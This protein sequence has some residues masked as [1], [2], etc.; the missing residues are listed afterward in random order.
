M[1]AVERLIRYCRIDTQ[2]DP[3]SNT[4]PSTAKQFDLAKILVRELKEV[5]AEDA[6]LDEY[7][8]VY[9]HI[10][11]NTERKVPTVGFIAH[12]DTA[13]DFTGAGVSPRIIENY[14]GRDIQ[15]N[16]TVVTRVSQFPQM[17]ELKGKTLLVTDGN[18]LLGADDKAGITA[19][20]EALCMLRDHPEIPHGR[21]AVAFTPDEEVGRGTEHF[22]FER[23]AADFAYTMDGDAVHFYSDETFNAASAK[24]TLHGLSVHPG[25][26]K[27]RMINALNAAMEF[28]ALLPAHMRPEHTEGREGFIHLHT[29]HGD[30][31]T[32]EMVYILREHGK[33]RFAR[34]KELVKE[35][36][37]HINFLY[38]EGTAEAVITDSYCN[39][40]EYVNEHPEV[41]RTALNAYRAL[42]IDAKCLPVRGGTDG[43]M[44]SAKG[45][46]C[47]NLGTGGN[48]FHGRYEYCCIEE[49]ETAADLILEIIRQIMEVK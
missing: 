34:L 16:E 35:A 4:S 27:D 37:R 33:E 29:M 12:M 47:P 23:F 36:E 30:T 43:A 3:L 13:P 20:M 46:P 22:D 25:S 7:C 45:L 11:A 1:S 39:M 9:G 28:H 17:K 18:T 26:A 48:N 32:A 14:D 41:I 38:G 24:V 5:G 8:Y 31:E 40:K 10:E 44:L 49:L 15:L 42:G 2:S 19:I 21:I 6:V